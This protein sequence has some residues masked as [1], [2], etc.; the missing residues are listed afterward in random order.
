MVEKSIFAGGEG[1]AKT[2]QT[3]PAI[4]ISAVALLG[5]LLSGFTHANAA[6]SLSEREALDIGTD[7]YIY[8][9]PLVT[10]E[11][12]RRVMTN[13][14]APDGKL[15]PMG[16][17]AKLREYP[18][19]SDK[20]VTAP[21]AD[22]LYCLAWLDLSSEPWVVSIP[23][24][25]DRYYLFPMLSGWTDVFQSPG[26]R[27]TGNG[28]QK[29]ALTGPGWKGTLPEGVTEYK[30][31]TNLV[32]VLGRIY[33]TGTPEDY[34]AVHAIQDELAVEPL[35]A[36]GKPYTPPV[37]T[38][39]PGIDMKTPVREQVNRMDA[40]S[41]FRLLAVLL[42]NNPPAEADAPIVEQMAK[43]G[44]IPGQEFDVSKLDPAV[45]MAL[46]GAPKAALEKIEAHSTEFGTEA[47][48]WRYSLKLGVYGTDYLRRAMTTAFGLGAN[49]P[50]DAVYPVS[51]ADSEGESYDGSNKYVLHFDK[52]EIPPVNGFWS[53][54]IYDT[55]YFFVQN[56]LKRYAISP[57]N[58]LKYNA[59]GSLDLYVQ[60]L[61]PG[62]KKEANW[63][64]APAQKFIL[65]LRLY[66]PKEPVLDGSWQTPGVDSV[67]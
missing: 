60:N 35:S 48:G 21:N 62:K 59:D 45:A 22:T 3:R 6:S 66:W 9:Y 10:M 11:M 19:P 37:G 2:M 20:E 56:P 51:V 24:T 15:A 25:K 26:K 14:A 54:T 53:L 47:N 44:I 34:T 13:A 36:Y 1:P 17:F 30:S 64:P 23:E 67:D 46:G 33:C 38:V 28:A 27:T 50:E 42:K 63:L 58:N 4:V 52:D 5:T 12:T 40:A 32:W 57:R 55:N 31:P 7:A 18:T 16:Q 43:V 41:Y 39:D 61:S 49:L 65:M 29:Y 8:G